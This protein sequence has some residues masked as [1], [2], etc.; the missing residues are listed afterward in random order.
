MQEVGSLRVGISLD[1]AKMEQS[2]ASVDRNLKA[3]GGEMAIIR[4]KGDSWG[5]STEGLTTKQK[6][7][8][9]MLESQDV[10]VRKLTEAH[11]K[12]VTEQG[13]NS[14]AAENL[15][16]KLNKAAAEYTKTET[17]LKS[18][19]T[20]L[21][22]Q[23]TDLNQT[24]NKWDDLAVSAGKAGDKLEAAG[25]KMKDVGGN[26]TAKVTTPILAV[27]AGAM[28]VAGQF[29][30]A[31][32][33]IQAQLG[34]TAE[35]A[36]KLSDVAED[37][38]KNAFGDSLVEVSDNLA[39]IKQNMGELSDVDLKKV[40]EGAY[41]IKD[42]FGAEINETTRT[43]SVLMKTFQID[44]T[45]ALDLITTGF[46]RGGNFS[47]ELVDSL[48]EYAPQFKGMG[49]NAEEF[50]AIL[51]AGAESGAFSLDKIG[52]AA[53]ESFL[54]IGDGSKSSRDALGNLGL[55]FE[56]IEE[57]INSGGESAKSAFAAVV[58]AIS[59]VE[60]P[61]AKA[62]MAVALLGTPI[63]DLGP[64][65]QDFFANVNTDLGDFEG[66]TK[67]AGD[68][69]YDNFG[70]RIQSEFRNFQASLEPAGEIL[71]D[72]AEDW[73]PKLAA[74]S[75]DV[76]GWFEDLGPEG[77]K[78]AL[79]VA[80]ITAA[81]GP[82]LVV[83]GSLSTGIGGVLRVAAPLA[84]ALGSGAGLAG[85]I[86]L[87]VNPIGLTVA[88]LGLLA[89]AIGVGVTAYKESNEVNIEALEAKQKEIEKND[90]LIESYGALRD[91]NQLSN[92]QMLR[93]LDIQAELET[94]NAPARVAALK[95]E[96][97]LLL[98]KSTLTNEEMDNFL[99]LNA[100]I[101]DA[102]PNTVKAISSQG[103]AFALNTIALKELNAEEARKLETGAKEALNDSLKKEVDL[104]N[105]SVKLAK[106]I[107]EIEANTQENSLLI[108][109]TR[110]EITDSEARLLD[111]EKQKNE[112]SLEEIINLDNKIKREQDIL[113]KANAQ[114]EEAK[115]LDETYGK[116]FDSRGKLLETNR[117]E[118]ALA[119][120]ARFK[121]EEIILAQAGITAERGRGGQQLSEE[122]SKLETQKAKLSELLSTGKINTAEYQEQNGKLDVQIS[123]LQTAQGKLQLINDTAGKTVYK[124]VNI[125]EYPKNFWDT[126][127]ENLR[128]PITKT[129][130]IRYNNMNGPQEP[131]RYAAGTR[132]APGGV[133]VLGESI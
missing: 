116:Q 53:K 110:Q 47:D 14:V 106:E 88:G 131:G 68:A 89:T 114:L 27:G 128:R 18:V 94:T 41:T 91:K 65:F 43:A 70:S 39:I 34:V 121:Y 2:L 71:L 67:K 38:W 50:T 62:Q 117:E 35:E 1:S 19:N 37:V 111:L 126:L 84:T 132:Y 69:L 86:G 63:E 57:D 32:G 75:E 8:S 6:T 45:K 80:G 74:A 124:D 82:A 83:V 73:L 108:K 119:E 93:F 99:G 24:S 42:A 115:H 25:E 113:N 58:A 21:S 123:K 85:T 78:V 3:L 76:L 107:N 11:Q 92:D 9:T 52:D 5:K 55:G 81:V 20:S 101:I 23:Q 87:L 31:Q 105:E 51:I 26:L 72:L 104:R 102:A 54:R 33:R 36:E 10:K 103:E 17:E 100:D 125:Q 48:R 109:Q 77:Q 64:E 44:S 59:T 90:N 4:A 16:I 112:A 13:A 129:V 66:S 97:A 120:E 118:I 28:L 133:A 15:A 98:E 122:I 46:Q 30:E 60:D 96:Q 22:K 79:S 29:D 61:A 7:L 12:A 56:Q 95:D 49:Y 127:D 40:A 130:S